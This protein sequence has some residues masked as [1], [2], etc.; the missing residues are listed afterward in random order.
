MAA[1][2]EGEQPSDPAAEGARSP[3]DWVRDILTIDGKI[4]E[5]AE[6]RIPRP[7]ADV[8]KDRRRIYLDQ[9][10]WIE[11]A[12]VH[13]GKSDKWAPAY[14]PL[15]KAIRSGRVSFPL[16]ISHLIESGRRGDDLSRARLVR[17]M[18]EIWNADAMVPWSHMLIP[19]AENAARRL[20]GLA[21]VDLE[22]VVFGKG[23]S[24]LLGGKPVLTPTKADAAPI[25][26]DK[27]A[28]LQKVL[29]DP[30]LLLSLESPSLSAELRQSFDQDAAWAKTFQEAIDREYAQP[31]GKAKHDAAI[32]RHLADLVVPEVIR[33]VFRICPAPKALLEA[34]LNSRE[35][36]E[37]LRRGLPTIDTFFELNHKRNLTRPVKAN[38]IWDW[39]LAIAIPYCDAV[40]TEGAWCNVAEE[41]GLATR[42]GTTMIHTPDGLANFLRG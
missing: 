20:C 16:S 41:T 28:T 24:H 21:E 5:P 12:R 10:V 2:V 42:W 40:A 27:L 22:G 39:A 11:L 3:E 18:A 4:K 17:F 32:A 38:D 14:E 15:L 23:I 34:T 36:F 6:G 19:E 9:W 7:P 35:E 1:N 31:T 26:A 30:R 25:P 37:E 33:A 8:G 13:Y 29:L